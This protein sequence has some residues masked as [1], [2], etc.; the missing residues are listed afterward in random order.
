MSLIY[1]LSSLP[2]LRFGEPSPIA[3]KAFLEAC[4]AQLSQTDA[5]AAEALLLG[6]DAPH[7]FV[8][9][10]RDRDAILR[11]AMART[12]ARAAGKDP[13]RWL[14]PVSGCDLRLE[15]LVEAALQ[16]QDPLQKERALDR[17]RWI[18]ADDLAGP[19]PLARERLFAY[20]IQLG[21]LT[22]WQTRD[23]EAGRQTF[24]KLTEVPITL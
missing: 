12:R 21:I 18:T 23:A 13:A 20:A 7:P 3:P 17:A 14:R 8:R 9:L 6:D 11:N 2:M 16:E 1:L 4:R 5:A 19:D 22:R 10:W 15:R 24:R